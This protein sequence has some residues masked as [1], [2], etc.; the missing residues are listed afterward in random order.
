M[1]TGVVPIA[2]LTSSFR[3]KDFFGVGAMEVAPSVASSGV[4]TSHSG[5]EYQLLR[6]QVLHSG[7]RCAVTPIKVQLFGRNDS[8]PEHLRLCAS[9]IWTSSLTCSKVQRKVPAGQRSSV[10]VPSTQ[11]LPALHNVRFTGVRHA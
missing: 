2:W 11:L 3:K 4:A 5:E 8:V 6:P 7:R 10:N 9:T 1:P